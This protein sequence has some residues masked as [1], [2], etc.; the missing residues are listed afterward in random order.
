MARGNPIV[1]ARRGSGRRTEG[2][3]L[4]PTLSGH[5]AGHAARAPAPVASGPGSNA[6]R[7]RLGRTARASPWPTRFPA[8]SGA[9]RRSPLGPPGHTIPAVQPSPLPLDEGPVASGPGSNAQRIRLGSP[10]AGPPQPAW[11]AG[12]HDPGSPTLA[13]SPRRGSGTSG[14]ARRPAGRRRHTP[15]AALV[16]HVVGSRVAP[17]PVQPAESAGHLG[18]TWQGV[19]VARAVSPD[20]LLRRDGPRSAS[21]RLRAAAALPR[22]PAGDGAGA[23]GRGSTAGG[24]T[25][26]RPGR[27]HGVARAERPAP[28]GRPRL[29]VAH[30]RFRDLW[31][32][33]AVDRPFHRELYVASHTHRRPGSSRGRASRSAFEVRFVAD[34]QL[35]RTVR[36]WEM[37]FHEG[38][39]EETTDLDGHLDHA[40]TFRETAGS[41]A[42]HRRCTRHRQ[43]GFPGTGARAVSRSVCG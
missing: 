9:G 4:H 24:C 26:T 23:G 36:V 5:L 37:N 40:T 20:D 17:R 13:A 12:A 7:I 28:P 21:L 32:H 3:Y 39:S 31:R 29:D 18:I 27:R 43:R 41:H 33:V 19:G 38:T 2:Q 34:W 42:D 8:P 35:D 14:T 11:T 25:G 15:V 10:R 1:H 22:G 30:R 16:G 6:Q